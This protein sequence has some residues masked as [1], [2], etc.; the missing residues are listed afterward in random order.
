MASQVEEEPGV[1]VVTGPKRSL[2]RPRKSTGL[3]QPGVGWG[4]RDQVGAVELID[5]DPP[6]GLVSRV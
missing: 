5:I 2:V 6:Q 4:Q 1:R 3:P